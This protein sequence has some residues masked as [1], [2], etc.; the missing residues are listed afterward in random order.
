[1]KPG[2]IR[3]L[4]VCVFRHNNHILAAEGYDSVKQERFYRPIGGRIEFGER[5]RE[6]IV[7]E[8]AEE[9]GQAVAG[10]SYL[11]TLE[12]IFTYE[13]QP[14]HEIVLV[15]DGQFV[16]K[17][18]YDCEELKGVED[19]EVLFTAYWRPLRYFEQGGAPLYPD[20]LLEL[21]KEAE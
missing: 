10:V 9:I 2:K 19:H 15:Y 13:G 8:V 7:R 14:G 12:S 17:T 4:A 6:T 1:M 20:G 18:V 3:P 11:G 16:D 21:L 5:G